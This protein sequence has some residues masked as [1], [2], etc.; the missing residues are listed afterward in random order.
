[1][2]SGPAS[3]NIY[4]P[5]VKWFK[6]MDGFLRNMEDNKRLTQDSFNIVGT[7]CIMKN[8]WCY[9]FLIFYPI[10]INDTSNKIVLET[11]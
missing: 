6:E 1:M 10:L 7:G 4:V 11:L 9:N 5:C 2:K 3:D 8:L